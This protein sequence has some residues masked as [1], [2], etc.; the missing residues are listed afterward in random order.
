[1]GRLPVDEMK[2]PL[3]SRLKRNSSDNFISQHIINGLLTELVSG[4]GTSDRCK[5]YTNFRNLKSYRLVNVPKHD[6]ATTFYKLAR[7]QDSMWVDS[8]LKILSGNS[9]EKKN[10]AEWL[11]TYFGKQYKEEMSAVTETMSFGVNKNMPSVYL[12]T[13]ST[14]IH[15]NMSQQRDIKSHNHDFFGCRMFEVEKDLKAKVTKKV[16]EPVHSTL[17]CVK[18]VSTEQEHSPEPEK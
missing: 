15:V 2:L 10:A 11:T 4:V 9:K 6:N 7:C 8:L 16:I 1:M 3:M 14:A 18:P 5:D 13:M 17:D 12:H